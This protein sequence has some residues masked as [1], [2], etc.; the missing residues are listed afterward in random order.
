MGLYLLGVIGG[1]R[2]LEFGDIGVANQYGERSRITTIPY[3]G[4]AM[5]ICKA[6][7]WQI[8]PSDKED[9]LAK[10]L[11]HQKILEQVMKRQFILPVKFGTIV[12]DEH[13]VINIL[14]RYR[15][16]LEKE[17]K[18]MKP[19]IEVDVVAVWDVQTMLKKIAEE[20]EE[21][22]E[23]KKAIESQP[24]DKRDGRDLMAIGMRLEEK[25]EE[26]RT[27][28]EKMIFEHLES[29]SQD[30]ADHERLEDRM[31]INSSFLIKKSGEDD[32]FKAMDELD[33]KLDRCLKFKCLS[34]L[35][36]H[37][38][39]TVVIEKLDAK[40]LKEAMKLFGVKSGTKLDAL[41]AKNRS[42]TKKHHPDKSKGDGSKFERINSSYKLLSSLFVD[43]RSAF[44]D[45]DVS[46]CF[47]LE[48]RRE[49]VPLC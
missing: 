23:M 20:D 8:K 31:V 44:S 28:V 33:R 6:N 32:F 41:K 22:K 35:P 10:L 14:G 5:A 30:R 26:K 42:L 27:E 11:E 13:D 40:E 7:G 1:E 18:E 45:V 2:G 17:I 12:E 39:R 46:R 43:D 37:S 36:P 24:Q 47:R 34:P 16:Q 48:I 3:G 21:I 38:F 49:G 19:F 15:V 4:V 25:L 9:L 29:L